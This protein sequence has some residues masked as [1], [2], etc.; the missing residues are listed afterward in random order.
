MIINLDTIPK[1]KFPNSRERA[2]FIMEEGYQVI[3]KQFEVN[4]LMREYMKSGTY[5]ENLGVQSQSKMREILNSLQRSSLR[6]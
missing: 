4:L 2:P 3:A 1:Q 6:Q 5:Y